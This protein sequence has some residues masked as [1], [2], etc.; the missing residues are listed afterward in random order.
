[1]RRRHPALDNHKDSTILLA[2]HPLYLASSSPRRIAFLEDLKLPFTCAPPPEGAEPSP[3]PGEQPREHAL[4]AALAKGERVFLAL[5]APSPATPPPVVIAADTVVSLEDRI[6]G[7]PVDAGQAL[8]MLRALS[9]R[10]H[11]VTTGCA[12]FCADLPAPRVFAAQ[13]RV[14][15]WDCPPELLRAYAESPEPLDKA[16]AYAVQGVGAFLVKAI[17]GSW[18]NVVGLPLAELVEE[19]LRLG[20]VTTEKEK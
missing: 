15:M 4:A 3:L 18:S 10:S 17:H 11:T 9:G 6:L 7:K 5:P 16:G 1:M 12:I 2:T 14:E 20:F 13:S 19:L 8:V